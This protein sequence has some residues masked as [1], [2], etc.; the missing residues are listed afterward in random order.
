MQILRPSVI[1]KISYFTVNSVSL[2][3]T[4]FEWQRHE[5]RDGPPPALDP[6]HLGGCGM[7]RVAR[8]V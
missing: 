6:S 1:V 7:G 2:V 4:T 8:C 5:P 3:G